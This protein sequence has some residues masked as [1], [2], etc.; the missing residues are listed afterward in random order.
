L[1]NRSLD[2]IREGR[3]RAIFKVNKHY[4]HPKTI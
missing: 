2:G 1:N 3:L 4:G